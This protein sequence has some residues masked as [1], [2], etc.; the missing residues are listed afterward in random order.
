MTVLILLNRG[1]GTDEAIVSLPAR[2]LAQVV[3]TGS[4]TGRTAGHLPA[5]AGSGSELATDVLA[6]ATAIR[7]GGDIVA[8]RDP[9]DVGRLASDHLNVAILAIRPVDSGRP[10]ASSAVGVPESVQGAKQ[11]R[12]GVV[13]PAGSA[14]G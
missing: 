12:G 7:L 5:A 13:E 9:V 2:G 11:V 8:T 6:V 1:K 4:R 14:G 3:T 10:G